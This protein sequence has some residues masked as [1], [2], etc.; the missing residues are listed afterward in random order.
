MSIKWR[1]RSRI[2]QLPNRRRALA[3]LL[4][5]ALS[6]ALAAMFLRQPSSEVPLGDQ[7]VVDTIKPQVCV[8]TLLENE[9]SEAKIKR[10]LELTREMGAGTIV[11]FFPWA[12][13]EST[14]DR[15]SWDRADL[16]V[17]HA[18]RQGL[19]IIA[20]LGFVPEWARTDSDSSV[21]TFNY[22]PEASFADFAEF[23]GLFAERFAGEI[24]DI[25]IWNEPNLSFEWGYRPV[26]PAAY[27]DLLRASYQKIK[28]ANSAA[29]V[30][31][32]ALA[33]TLETRSSDAGVNE[34]DYLRDMYLH[35][36]GDYFDAL[37]VHSYGFIH[38]PEM[39]PAAK[40]L[41][42]RRAELLREIM[43][44]NGDA[45]KAVM[46]TES[47]WND[48]P[49]WTG[50][51]RPSQRSAYTVAAFEYAEENWDWLENLCI[52]ALRYPADLKSYPDGYTLINAEFLRKPI[53]FAL[54]DYARGW[55]SSETLWLPPPVVPQQQ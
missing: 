26:D 5:I 21:T 28:E 42:F 35:G 40:L 11:Q 31:A 41:N 47:G 33:P 20:R 51:V 8:H 6:I 48:H 32:G 43:V 50:A 7:Q 19:R 18:R 52:W 45:D 38:P 14:E 49:R 4:V 37:A 25:I 9:V 17:R 27:V 54:Q 15:Y 36:A 44:M 10:S 29:V 16:I 53:Y 30:L 34:L 24:E 12:Y 55:Q 46:I 39:A 3:A 1:K 2:S 22:L 23:A 13:F